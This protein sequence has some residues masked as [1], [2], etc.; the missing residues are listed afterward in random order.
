VT[1]APS[2]NFPS[3]TPSPPVTG[4]VPLSTNETPAEQP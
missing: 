2:T 3:P 1:T 4:A